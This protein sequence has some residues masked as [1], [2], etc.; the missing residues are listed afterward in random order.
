VQLVL[1][2][3]E[4]ELGVGLGR[5]VVS[6]ESQDLAHS[7]VAPPLTGADVADPLAQLV[8]V[9]GV[10]LAGRVL[11]ALVV[12]RETLDQVLGQARGRRLPEL[13]AAGAPDAVAHGKNGGEAVVL[14]LAGDLALALESNYP[15]FPDGCRAGQLTIFE[16]VD[17]VLVDRPHVRARQSRLA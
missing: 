13:R 17:E 14:A 5:L 1:H 6:S 8:N 15:E 4:E 7:Q 3:L 16:D 10:P 2:E 12:D 9:V 11:E